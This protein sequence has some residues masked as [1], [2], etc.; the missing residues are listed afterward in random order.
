MNAIHKETE[1]M[2]YRVE[3]L[4]PAQMPS[5]RDRCYKLVAV[6][7]QFSLE[8]RL[9][10][11]AGSRRFEI[12]KEGGKKPCRSSRGLELTLWKDVVHSRGVGSVWEE[13]W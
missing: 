1:E 8:V 9:S 11:Q 12:G 6:A 10:K 13:L 5:S 2:G 3:G 7:N 4:R